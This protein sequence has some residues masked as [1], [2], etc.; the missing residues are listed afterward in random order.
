[1]PTNKDFKRLVRTRMTKTGESYTT[2]R[3]QL[4]KKQRTPADAGRRPRR[5]ATAGLPDDYAN[6]AGMSDEA[7]KAKT[8]CAWPRWVKSLD[9]HGAAAMS[10]REIATLIHDTYELDGWWTQMVA[11]GYER[12]RGLRDRGQR[13][14]G[15]YEASK[16]KTIAVSLARLY[17]AFSDASTR[18]RWLPD[19]E[20]DLR[21]S[22]LRK[23]MR[24]RWGDGSVVQLNFVAK[25][26][27]KSQVTVQH[28]KLPD[29]E[30]AVRVKAFWGKRLDA[31]ATLLR[32]RVPK[33]R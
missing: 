12:L 7:V 31:L 23:S 17:R 10:H 25:A 33:T 2:A 20:F 32:G 16:S 9:H 26:K 28:T 29:K 15:A 11:V 5:T 30:A 1:M 21:S 27:D 14:G 3:A 4:L 18:R 24:W 8:G 19:A 13:R 6:I 22:R